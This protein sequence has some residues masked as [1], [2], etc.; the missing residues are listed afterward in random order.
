MSSWS[1]HEVTRHLTKH[2]SGCWWG[3]CWMRLTIE[4]V[5]WVK[6]LL[7]LMGMSPILSAESL[8]RDKRLILPQV[9]GNSS[10]L[11]AFKLGHQ[12]CSAFGLE[13]KHW[14]F[15]HLKS[16][17]LGMGTIPLTLQGLQLANCRSWDLSASLTAWAN[18]SQ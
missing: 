17:N 7:S 1:D 6:R 11:T 12:I 4:L 14:L 3:S 10:C 16:T 15:L 18:F 9:R 8:S 13:L 2:Y 5:D